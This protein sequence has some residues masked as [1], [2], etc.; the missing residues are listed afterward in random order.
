[1]L[2]AVLMARCA[3]V[4]NI[5]FELIDTRAVVSCVDKSDPSVKMVER[6]T[7]GNYAVVSCERNGQ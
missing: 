1:M 3:T 2:L 5:K 6:P 4:G 7:G